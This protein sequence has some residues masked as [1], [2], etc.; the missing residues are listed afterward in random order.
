MQTFSSDPGLATV[1]VCGS[2]CG[3]PRSITGYSSSMLKPSSF[4]SNSSIVVSTSANGIG[5]YS[6]SRGGPKRGSQ[7]EKPRT[8]AFLA[9]DMKKLTDRNSLDCR[10]TASAVK[11]HTDLTENS[12]RGAHQETS[13]ATPKTFIQKCGGISSGIDYAKHNSGNSLS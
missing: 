10:G 4:K 7:L 9:R 11:A 3:P 8:T 13:A 5:I 1:A 12:D 6:C 2:T